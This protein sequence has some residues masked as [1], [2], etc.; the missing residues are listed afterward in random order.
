MP[1]SPLSFPTDEEKNATKLRFSIEYTDFYT[2]KPFFALYT[3]LDLND[4]VTRATYTLLSV[5][6]SAILAALLSSNDTYPDMLH[7]ARPKAIVG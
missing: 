1:L 7:F 2:V 4:G 6:P 3:Y 5:H